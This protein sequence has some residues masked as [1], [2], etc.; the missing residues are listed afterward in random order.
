MP[1]SL[2]SALV[3]L[4]FQQNPG[5]MIC[6]GISW[7]LAPSAHQSHFSFRKV[8][9]PTKRFPGNLFHRIGAVLSRQVISAAAAYLRVL[10]VNELFHAEVAEIRECR[11]EN[12]L[13]VVG[14]K[15]VEWYWP[16]ALFKLVKSDIRVDNRTDKHAA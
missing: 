3:H 9:Y 2:S 7:Y 14:R 1:Q 11:R 15:D 4:V 5:L 16:F 13:P 10:C 6:L 8:A 12:H